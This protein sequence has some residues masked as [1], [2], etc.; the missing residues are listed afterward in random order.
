MNVGS[1]ANP[2]IMA[3]TAIYEANLFI[4]PSICKMLK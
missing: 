4:F 1:A 3:K 2:T